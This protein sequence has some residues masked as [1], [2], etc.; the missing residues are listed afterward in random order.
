VADAEGSAQ[1][2]KKKQTLARIA[3]CSCRW[4]WIRANRTNWQTAALRV[5]VLGG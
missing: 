4:R 1:T 2:A 3:V 5:E